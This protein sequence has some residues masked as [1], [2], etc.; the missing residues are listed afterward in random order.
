MSEGHDRGLATPSTDGR[1]HL[2]QV[3]SKSSAE[4]KVAVALSFTPSARR[5]GMVSAA[6]TVLFSALYAATLAAALLSLKSPQQPIGDP[7]F[8]ILEIS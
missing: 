1:V 2:C 6:G 3:R 4:R 5:L 8:A 7:L